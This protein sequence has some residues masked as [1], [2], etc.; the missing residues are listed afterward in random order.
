MWNASRFCVS[1]LRRGY[2]NLL[3]KPILK[4]TCCN[5]AMS[6]YH[7][8]IVSWHPDTIISWLLIIPFWSNLQ[9][10]SELCP[11]FEMWVKRRLWLRRHTLSPHGA[12]SRGERERIKVELWRVSTD[13]NAAFL[14]RPLIL[15]SIVQ[16]IIERKVNMERIKNSSESESQYL[17]FLFGF[18]SDTICQ[19]KKKHKQIV[20][21]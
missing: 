7:D 18:V 1:S 16:L 14:Q 5:A 13:A 2:A 15:R 6:W 4:P 3:C 20:R 17:I 21:R 11:L 9:P 8:A 12:G 19:T 10:N